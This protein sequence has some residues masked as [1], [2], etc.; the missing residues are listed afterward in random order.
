MGGLVL[1]EH[2]LGYNEVFLLEIEGVPTIIWEPGF[3][4]HST[5]GARSSCGYNIH[6]TSFGVCLIYTRDVWCCL[7][8]AIQ[9]KC[10]RMM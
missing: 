5:V 4:R 8:I 9:E 1:K 6:S 3:M 2:I 7:V 10:G